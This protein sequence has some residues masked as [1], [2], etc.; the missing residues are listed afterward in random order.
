MSLY[1]P[2]WGNVNTYF[3]YDSQK[4]KNV[5]QEQIQIRGQNNAR[6]KKQYLNLEESQE[7]AVRQK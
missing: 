3:P 2:L 4:N 6:S 1:E 7:K 5:I